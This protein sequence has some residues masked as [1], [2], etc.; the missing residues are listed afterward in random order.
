VFRLDGKRIASRNGSP[1]KVSV[2]ATPGRHIV[3]ARVTFKDATR[4]KTLTTR[5]RA[6]AAA[7]LQPRPGPS[8]FTG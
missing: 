2:K 1:F 4:A 8:S 6:C 5:Y 7:S 3:S